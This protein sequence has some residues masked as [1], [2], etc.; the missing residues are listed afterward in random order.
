MASQHGLYAYALVGELPG[1]LPV[2][3]IDQQQDIY[4]IEERGLR[5]LV[6]NIDVEAF[7]HRVKHAF[8]EL[9]SAAGAAHQG[10]SA[11]LQA[12][13]DVVDA[14]MRQTTVVPFKFG[15]LLKDEAAASQMLLNEEERF[16]QLLAR[17]ANKAEWGLKV[18]A[19]TGAL[20]RHIAS[21]EPG[22]AD[23]Q[24]QR[25]TLA[26]GAAYLLGKKLEQAIKDAVAA[27]LASIT[28]SIFQQASVNAFEAKLSKTLPQKLTGKQQEMVL[29]AAYLVEKTSAARF[30]QQ[31]KRLQE[32]YTS[33]GL[34]LE[35]SGPWPPYNF[36]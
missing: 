28:E 20:T 14:L 7:Q 25:E 1:P 32:R 31:G 6:S 16:K 17:F 21:T 29:N 30:C 19:N 10:T 18:Y 4:A 3:G 33:I 35:L 5:V 26:P 23:L 12:H 15:T 36:T 24:R 11:L 34:E 13:E 27:R 22:I 8:A 9:S 2:S